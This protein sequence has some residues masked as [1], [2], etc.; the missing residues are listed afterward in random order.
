MEKVQAQ[1]SPHPVPGLLGLAL[2][3]LTWY[4]VYLSP[5]VGQGPSGGDDTACSG[6]ALVLCAG[7]CT[8]PRGCPAPQSEPGTYCPVKGTGVAGGLSS[9]PLR[10]RLGASPCH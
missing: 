2:A 3:E 1:G 7:Q 4:P 10:D 9:G 8:E 6:R 5:A